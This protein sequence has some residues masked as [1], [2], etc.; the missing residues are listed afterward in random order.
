MTDTPVR[1]PAAVARVEVQ[2]ASD[3]MLVGD[4]VT[5]LMRAVNSQGTVLTPATVVWS[6]ADSAT[7]SVSSAGV[8]RGRNV[9]SVRLAVLAGGVVGEATVRVVTRPLRLRLLAPDTAEIVD[10]VELTSV[11]ETSAGQ[12]LPEVA[13]RFDV[14]DTS[15]ATVVPL[16]VGRARLELRRPGATELLAVVGRDT[17][18]RTL[19]VRLAALRSFQLGI[20]SRVLGL[21]DSLPYTISAIDTAGRAVASLGTTLTVEPAGTVVLRGGHLIARAIGRVIVHAQYGALRSRDTITAQGPSEFP[22]DLVDGDGQRPLPLRVLLS[23]E[24]VAAKWRRVIRT[25][26]PGDFVRLSIGE[27]RNAVPVSQFITGVRVLVKL[28]SLPSR[29]AGL[30]GPCVMRPNGLPL[31]GTLSLNILTVAQ[32][33]E[34]K[35]DDLIQHEVGHIL[36]IGSL[37]ARGELVALVSGDTASVDPIF[38]GPSALTAFDKLGR[39]NFFNGRRVP[40]EVRVLG[41]WRLNAFSGELMAPALT[42]NAPQALS[43]VTVAALRDLGWNVELEAYDEYVLPDL[44]VTQRVGTPTGLPSA[45]GASVGTAPSLALEG[46]VL[47]PLV[48]LHADGTKQRLD[49]SRWLMK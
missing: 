6:T 23:M 47:P 21:G 13:P 28:D 4:S 25:A 7:G 48:H 40:L 45:R 32:L 30:G 5:A 14:T 29:I 44:V 35:L 3:S 38:V 10:D 12:T 42:P 37:W 19:T 33:S 49:G 43:S 36:G 9:G 31:L 16:A 27:C 20:E 22:L 41:H 17:T 26:P 11:V 46:D 2:L 24:R 18:R 34:R 8:L 1:D 39:S 15:I